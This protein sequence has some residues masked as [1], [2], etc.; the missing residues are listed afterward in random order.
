MS[1]SSILGYAAI[2]G[3]LLTLAVLAMRPGGKV[4]NLLSPLSHEEKKERRQFQNRMAYLRRKV[5]AVFDK[6]DSLTTAQ[7]AK[8]T[9]TDETFVLEVL[10][11]AGR[12]GE[13]AKNE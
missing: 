6:T 2:V 5:V 13:V 10:I 1:F 4:I 11:S 7:I 3:F 12:I 9:G 8:M